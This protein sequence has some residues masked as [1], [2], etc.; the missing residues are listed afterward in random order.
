MPRLSTLSE[1]RLLQSSVAVLALV[2]VL[3]GAAGVVFGLGAFGVHDDL[4]LG[5]DSHVRYLSGLVLAIGLGF[6]STVP[7]IEVQGARFRMLTG[8]VLIGGLARLYAVARYGVPPR[9]MLAALVMELAVTPGLAIWRESVGRKL[10][11]CP[12]RAHTLRGRF[13]DEAARATP[14]PCNGATKA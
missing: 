6:W 4:P 2:P 13:L 10:A 3:A 8:L 14:S 1:R 12:A 7:G 11:H 9:P 5:G